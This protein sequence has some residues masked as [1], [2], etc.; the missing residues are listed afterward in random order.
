M[1]LDLNPDLTQRFYWLDD[2]DRKYAIEAENRILVM[3][4]A[5]SK[6]LRMGDNFWLY[7]ENECWVTAFFFQWKGNCE[8]EIAY[9]VLIESQG[10][11]F[12][13][14]RHLYVNAH[15]QGYVS[16]PGEVLAAALVV[17]AKEINPGNK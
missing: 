5:N 17:L 7:Y 1:T 12:D 11:T 9:H 16:Y 8:D 15:E 14:V 4:A 10:T 6:E 13:G 2:N 3:R